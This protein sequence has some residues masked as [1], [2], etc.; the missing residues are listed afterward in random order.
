[1][2]FDAQA[3][4]RK[5]GPLPMWGWGAVG[6]GAFVV[7]RYIRAR[8]AAASSA[9]PTSANYSSTVPSN[10]QEPTATLSTPSGFSY[11]GP[12]SGLQSLLP[13]GALAS[14]NGSTSGATNPPP[15]AAPAP[16]L[17]PINAANYP[18]IVKYGS[19]GPGDYTQIGTITGP[20]G[21][22]TGQNVSGGAPVYANAFGGFTQGFNAATLPVGTGIY[23]PS[24]L[25]AY[26]SGNTVTET[27]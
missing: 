23:I 26:E 5:V 7:F 11:T 15:V 10:F 18:S 17:P 22:Y 19:Y 4:T 2:P 24:S 20:G 8:Q 6:I 13:V 1:M 9:T 27:L 3:L 21:Q 12:L 14:T 25:T 16:S